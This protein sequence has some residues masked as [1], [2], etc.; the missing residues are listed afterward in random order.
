MA[1]FAKTGD[2]DAGVPNPSDLIDKSNKDFVE[3]IARGQRVGVKTGTGL[4][5]E[6]TSDIDQSEKY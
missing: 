1:K 2:D 5:K 6:G 3:D 4:Y